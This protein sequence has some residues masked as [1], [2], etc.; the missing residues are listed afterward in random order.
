MG[1]VGM[2]V[3]REVSTSIGRHA[4]PDVLVHRPQDPGRPAGATRIGNGPVFG[5]QI[6]SL[7]LGLRY[8]TN[9]EV[10]AFVTKMMDGVTRICLNL[11]CRSG[12]LVSNR[13]VKSAAPCSS[14]SCLMNPTMPKLWLC[15]WTRLINPSRRRSLNAPDTSF[16]GGR[17]VLP[18]GQSDQ[19]P[20]PQSSMT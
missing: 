8:N 19:Y 11:D 6:T 10:S 7:S 20:V 9:H 13:R 18:S 14:M 15:K 4:W 2:C 1:Y 3:D 16:R 12:F 5:D 17:Y